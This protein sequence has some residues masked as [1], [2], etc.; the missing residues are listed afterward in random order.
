[1][2]ESASPARRPV[3][4][5]TGDQRLAAGL[6]ARV[7]DPRHCS[8][9]GGVVDP[10]APEAPPS[11]AQLFMARAIAFVFSTASLL[12]LRRPRSRPRSGALAASHDRA[13]PIARRTLTAETRSAVSAGNRDGAW[14]GSELPG[15]RRGRTAS[16]A[17]ATVRGSDRRL[18][19]P[20]FEEIV[21]VMRRAEH[22]SLAPHAD[23]R[24]M[25][26]WAPDQRGRRRHRKRP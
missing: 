25:A 19:S 8:S 21:A 24:A 11:G 22:A 6:A 13:G 3:P 17:A 15:Y 14:S 23:R 20:S 26:R 12:T 16:W 10:L 2:T 7:G 18:M 4:S 9:P 5:R 1:L